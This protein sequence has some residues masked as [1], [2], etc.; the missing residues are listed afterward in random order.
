VVH[1]AKEY[2]WLNVNLSAFLQ[3]SFATLPLTHVTR[4]LP[5]MELINPLVKLLARL[6]NMC[7]AVML[8]VC[9][10]AVV[11][12]FPKLIASPLANLPIIHLLTSLGTTEVFRFQS[13]TLR[14]SGMP[15]LLTLPFPSL[16]HLVPFGLRGLS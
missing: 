1:P 4:Q 5:D 15:K 12:V 6:I 8:S 9:P 13:L 10:P 14:V 11:G 16:N 3:P 7:A 2:L